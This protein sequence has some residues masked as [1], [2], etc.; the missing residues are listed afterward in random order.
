[1]SKKGTIQ[2][3]VS[4][5]QELPLFDTEVDAAEAILSRW[6]DSEER[7]SEPEVDTKPK[8][9]EPEEVEDSDADPDEQDEVTDEDAEEESEDDGEEEPDAEEEDSQE[10]EDEESEDTE[11]A[12]EEPKKAKTLEDDSEV[13]IKV[14]DEVHKVSVKDLKRLWGQEAALTKKSQQV[15]TQRKQVEE[16]GAKYSVGLQKLYE[17]AQ[18][19]WEPYSKIDMLIASKQLDD[20]QFTQLRSEAQ[21]AYEEFAFISQEVDNF[22]KDIEQQR[23]ENLRVQAAES[24]KVLKEK[25]PNWSNEMYDRIR[26]FAI[27]NGMEA[28]VVNNIVDPTAIMILN[29]ARLYDESQKIKLKKTVKAP[30]KI[31]K[32]GTMTPKDVQVD[33]SAKAIQKLRASGSVDD[34]ADAF[35]S[36]WIDN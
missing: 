25:L 35:M 27:E 36:R 29:K 19:K 2:S 23:Q 12:D 31:L 15:A 34:A 7:T 20:E 9:K 21:A 26:T 1:M 5:Q 24:V 3:D 22:V 32:G 17:K 13:E 28:Q 14:D 18:S 16:Q 6:E 4:Q 30:K 11:E 8:R 10:S 33:K